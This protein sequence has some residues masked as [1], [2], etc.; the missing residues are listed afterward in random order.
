MLVV[1]GGH[2]RNIGKTSVMAGIIRG[3][4]EAEWTAVKITQ[5]GHGICSQTGIACG[6]APENPKDPFALDEERTPNETDTGRYLAAGAARSYWLRAPQG[7]LG[8]AIG[9]VR[10]ILAESRNA[11]LESNSI[12]RYIRPDLYLV[13]LDFSVEDIKESSRRYMDRADVFVVVDRG[14]RRP[15]WPVPEKW[16]KSKPCFRVQPGEFTSAELV[17]WVRERLG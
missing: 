3:L 6:C 11:I 17:D 14:E 15:P 16:F 7:S 13:V 5:H 1:V 2:S 12:M 8:N 10:E 4:R 9:A